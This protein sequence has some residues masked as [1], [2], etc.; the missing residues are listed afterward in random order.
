MPASSVKRDQTIG[1]TEFTN[2]IRV[3][4]ETLIALIADIIGDCFTVEINA[5]TVEKDEIVFAREAISRRTVSGAE[6]R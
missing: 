5:V 3:E 6:G 2:L 1:V 4:C